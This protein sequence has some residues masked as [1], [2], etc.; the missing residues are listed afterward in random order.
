MKIAVKYC[1]TGFS[2]MSVSPSARYEKAL[3]C[4]LQL[5]LVHHGCKLEKESKHSLLI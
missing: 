5:L 4:I 3:L 1:W 2:S